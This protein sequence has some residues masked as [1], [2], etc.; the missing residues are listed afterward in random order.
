MKERKIIGADVKDYRKDIPK[1]LKLPEVTKDPV[2][3]KTKPISKEGR[4]EFLKLDNL[5]KFGTHGF[6]KKLNINKTGTI[7]DKEIK[8]LSAR[9]PV[10]ILSYISFEFD[11]FKDIKN[12]LVK[13]YNCIK[14]VRLENNTT[15]A[16]VEGIVQT[17]KLPMT[18][19]GNSSRTMDEYVNTSNIPAEIKH[20]TFNAKDPIR[21]R[22]REVF[23]ELNIRTVISQLI[24]DDMGEMG[25]N[26][27]DMSEMT[28]VRYAKR[29]L[30]F[31]LTFKDEHE[32]SIFINTKNVMAMNLSMTHQKF[33][34]L[35]TEMLQT[36]REGSN[37]TFV[38]TSD[39]VNRKTRDLVFAR[40]N[41]AMV[42]NPIIEL[43]ELT[44]DGIKDI[45]GKGGKALY[46]FNRTV[47]PNYL[48]LMGKSKKQKPNDKTVKFLFGDLFDDEPV[49]YRNTENKVFLCPNI[50]KFALFTI[51]ESIVVPFNVGVKTNVDSIAIA[52][53][54]VK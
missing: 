25:S 46:M 44:P 42:R 47:V 36:I 9:I 34:E 32:G 23:V 19:L 53:E 18:L 37:T 30:Y 21:L 39:I 54:A 16:V 26:I 41:M 14:D 8:D 12:K 35:S 24:L 51:F 6:G 50:K 31:A 28:A 33:E 11:F 13:K 45:E 5:D 10:K 49:Y 27:S 4:A 17:N 29:K 2:K 20:L 48:Q 52:L 43:V 15:Y 40:N 38:R 1:T 7:F 22:N 3:T